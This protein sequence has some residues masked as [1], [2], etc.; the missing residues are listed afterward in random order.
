M[1]YGDFTEEGRIFRINTPSTPSEWTNYLFNDNYVAE[2][3]QTL[4][5]KSAF[6]DDYSRHD[7]TDGYRNFYVSVGNDSF[8]LNNIPEDYFC[9][10][11]LGETRIHMEKGGI[12]ADI[13]VFVPTK[14][15]CEVW[16]VKL[17]NNSESAKEVNLFSV[18]P[19]E[20]NGPMGGCSR[21]TDGFI[22]KYS[23]PY[24]VYYEDKKK[25]EHN[26]AYYY[27]YSDKKPNSY[28][29]D[30]NRFYGCADIH[31]IPEAVRSGECK[32]LDGEG[33]GPFIGAMQHSLSLDC[34]ECETISF[35][36]GAETDIES[37]KSFTNS[38]DID[39]EYKKLNQLWNKR[40]N[41]LYI[42]T[43]DK[44]I[45]YM[46]N[47]WVKK[48]VILLTRL[49]RMSVYCPVRNQLQD[50]LGYSM[51]EPFEAL[52][53][54]L[55]V[56]RRQQ[57]GGFLKQ[58]YMTDGSKER[59]LCLLNH[60]DAPIWLIL[61]V[62][63]IIEQCGDMSIYDREERYIDTDC[64]DS[65]YVHLIKAAHSIAD[66]RGEH[67]LCLMLDGDWTDPINGA[68]RLGKGESTW[69]SEAAA[70]AVSRLTAVAEARNDIETA[71]KLHKLEQELV[72]A[73]NEHCYID[74]YYV[75][76]FDDNGIPFGKASDEEGSI[77]LNAQVWAIICG[78]A[79]GEREKSV[80]NIINSLETDFGS[81]LLYP[82]FSTWNDTWGRI[83]IKQA[84]TTENGSVYCH[85]SMFKAYSD[86]IRGD[87]ESAYRTL[88][89]TL[90][91]NPDN[92]PS[93]NG[94]IPLFIPNYYFALEGSA[95]MGKSS[96]NYGT[97]SAAWFL[98]VVV[99]HMLGK[100]GKSV[101]P[102]SWENKC[103]IRDR[104]DK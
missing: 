37:I 42:D 61:C 27:M 45:N 20:Q 101:M 10:H 60:S 33:E 52:K 6:V 62:V 53:Y 80:L 93:K 31:C 4:K 88:L 65:I 9:E 81:R 97:G 46:V 76:G 41:S 21:Y 29:G 11:G 75:T 64:T 86:C 68:G 95:N 34:G 63:E 1:K 104:S 98:W 83:S 24:H 57:S 56:L 77:F 72:E 43:P 82:A 16:R 14:A 67:G 40:I 87:G 38:F 99:K 8:S 84:G 36:I 39:E 7:F 17:T 59:A 18:I 2:I 100:D 28:E 71:Q 73:V 47:Y 25:V 92:P 54:A 89:K 23:F 85:A 91:T 102:N 48:Q 69:S 90:P 74:G 58:W 44:N 35:I 96:C 19:F 13:S 15:R 51:V 5:G 32:S 79:K 12:S 30:S 3:S 66:M 26:K 49:N 50:A 78:A 22:Y 55:N 94:Q 103:L 70:Y